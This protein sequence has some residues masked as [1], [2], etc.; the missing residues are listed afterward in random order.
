M[1]MQDSRA[2]LGK[3]IQEL[4]FRWSETQSQWTDVMSEH[5]QAERLLPLEADLR[6]AA[7]AMDQ[8]GQILNKV[9]RDC[10]G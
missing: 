8:M 4:M 5:F 9:R 1:S 3:A 10:S 7:Q 2:L 6:T